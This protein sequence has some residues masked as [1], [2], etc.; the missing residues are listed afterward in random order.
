M[1]CWPLIVYK[2]IQKYVLHETDWIQIVILDKILLDLASALFA[3]WIS[4]SI[5]FDSFYVGPGD[6]CGR[7]ILHGPIGGLWR[8]LP[9]K[10]PRRHAIRWAQHSSF[11]QTC[12]PAG[13]S[14]STAVIVIWEVFNVVVGVIHL[15]PSPTEGH[16]RAVFFHS[17][18]Q[19]I[20][21]NFELP[22]HIPRTDEFCRNIYILWLVPIVHDGKLWNRSLPSVE[23]L[24]MSVRHC[25]SIGQLNML[26]L[27]CTQILHLLISHRSRPLAAPEAAKCSLTRGP[28]RANLT[29]AKC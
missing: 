25:R 13:F 9:E 16:C 26:A 29:F 15:G 1:I 12:Q 28:T 22:S 5:C 6:D 24:S 19:L 23:P 3:D 20:A 7:S 18:A 11:T 14:T 17:G 8:S 4:R 2:A 10:T 21:D 27:Q